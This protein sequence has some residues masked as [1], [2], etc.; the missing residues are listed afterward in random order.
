MPQKEKNIHVLRCILPPF[1]LHLFNFCKLLVQIFYL[2]QYISQ[3]RLSSRK[4]Q[5]CLYELHLIG[6][7]NWKHPPEVFFNKRC[8]QKF[9]KIHRKTPVPE[10]LFKNRFWHRC[11]PADFAKFLRTT[12]LQNTSERL[13]GPRAIFTTFHKQISCKVDDVINVHLSNMK[14]L[15]KISTINS[16]C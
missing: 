9:R 15:L 3:N 10:S 12:F 7:Y 13:Y 1:F 5:S 6:F 4:Q 11:F 8:S 14:K 2:F 16:V